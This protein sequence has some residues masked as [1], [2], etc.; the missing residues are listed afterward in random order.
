MRVWRFPGLLAAAS[1]VPLI[2]ACLPA[3]GHVG[4]VAT[5]HFTAEHRFPVLIVAW[6]EAPPQQIDLLSEDSGIHLIATREFEGDSMEVDLSAPGDS[7]RII[8][9]D[10][11]QVYRLVPGAST[12]EY[13]VGV[14]SEAADPGRETVHD[15]GTVVFTTEALATDQGVYA[16][17]EGPAEAEFVSEEEFPPGC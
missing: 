4:A 1:L 9:G 5:G 3:G 6:C 13:L 2:S 14:G 16:S 17:E 12:Q 10:G 7:W 8:D 15:I 11:R